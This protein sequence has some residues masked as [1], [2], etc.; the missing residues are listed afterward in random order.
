MK[1]NKNNIYSLINIIENSHYNHWSQENDT[2]NYFEDKEII[3]YA[4]VLE[5]MNF[6]FWPNYNWKIIYEGKEYYS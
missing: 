4:F 5:S 2:F 6:C 3:I 1:I